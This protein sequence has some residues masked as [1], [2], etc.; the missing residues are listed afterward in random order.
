MGESLSLI[1][2]VDLFCREYILSR[3]ICSL[4]RDQSVSSFVVV[5][6]QHL[7]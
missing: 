4:L 2:C 6:D 7:F 5:N 3:M 1:L